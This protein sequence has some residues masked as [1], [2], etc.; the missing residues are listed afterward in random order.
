MRPAWGDT[1]ENDLDAFVEK[2]GREVLRIPH[3]FFVAFGLDVMTLTFCL[4][5]GFPLNHQK[6]NF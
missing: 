5:L 4:L 1:P 3:I 6:L 2:S